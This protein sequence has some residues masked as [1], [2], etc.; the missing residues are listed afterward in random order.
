MSLQQQR[1]AES[2]GRHRPGFW[3]YRLIA[4]VVLIPVVAYGIH[5]STD[6]RKRIG[7]IA[8]ALLVLDGIDTLILKIDTHAVLSNKDIEC[9]E[10]Y[11][12]ADKVVDQVQYAAALTLLWTYCGFWSP[13][14][15]TA[16]L[17]RW[18]GVA[19]FAHDGSVGAKAKRWLALFPDV[20]K[21]LLLLFAVMGPC[22]SPLMITLTIVAK[23]VFE[24]ARLVYASKSC[25]S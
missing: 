16:Y 1:Q 19:L 17:L 18:I 20:T 25:D 12:F 11:Q 10:Q 14:I 4:T 7:I 21:E 8:F 5:S 2:L 24:L 9:S 23:V 13:V 3:I 22:A 15:A 6:C